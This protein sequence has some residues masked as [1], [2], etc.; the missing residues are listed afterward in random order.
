MTPS[1]SQNDNTLSI[2]IPVFNEENTLEEL[3]GRVQNAAIGDIKKEIVLVDDCSSDK[4]RELISRYTENHANATAVFHEV[5]QGKGAALQT[6]FNKC[7]GDWILIQDADLEYDPDEYVQLLEPILEGKAD[8]V[9]GSRFVSSRPR[10]VVYFWHSVG[11][12]ILTMFSNMCSDI[13]LTDMETC[14]KLFSRE[15]I[16]QIS[17]E[18]KRFGFEPEITAKVARGNYR[19]YEVGISYY[20]RTYSEG[21]KIGWKDGVRAF[22][23]IIKYNFFR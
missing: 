20:G 7:T 8:V 21:K 3:L 11:N 6:G 2:V 16:S 18:E 9:Y 13:N 5:N 17:I 19:I 22:Y 1:I 23:C 12:K 4:S 10:R 14:Y 15:V